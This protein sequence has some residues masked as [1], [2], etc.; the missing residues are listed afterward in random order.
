MR[1]CGIA[2]RVTGIARSRGYDLDGP[3]DLAK[4][5]TVE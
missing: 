3:R 5:V 2:G 4:S 1:V